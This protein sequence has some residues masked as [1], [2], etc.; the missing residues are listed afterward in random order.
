MIGTHQTPYAL[1]ASRSA[2]QLE[3][4]A[5]AS[6]KPNMAKHL[7]RMS[8]GKSVTLDGETGGLDVTFAAAWSR[9]SEAR[10]GKL[11]LGI[12]KGLGVT[13]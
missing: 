2:R 6:L 11:R 7:A 4:A 9:S 3:A 5:A 13:C 1:L 10:F 8:W 12:C